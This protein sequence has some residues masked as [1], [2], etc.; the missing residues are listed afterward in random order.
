MRDRLA[1]RRQGARLHPVRAARPSTS[2]SLRRLLRGWARRSSS[3]ELI[4]TTGGSE[5]IL[6]AF[7][8]AC[9]DGDEVLVVEPFYTNY[10]AFATMAGVRL[11]PLPHARRG[12]L[13]PAAAR[14]LGA[15]AHAAHAAV[16]LCNPNNPTGTVY[17]R[18]EIEM[19]GR[20]SAATTASS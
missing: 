1:R 20:R 19:R 15:R 16:L 8:A 3:S 18:E 5:A 12:R 6:F 7:F 14:G 2:T 4:A 10:N 11:V 13:P 9:A 17:T